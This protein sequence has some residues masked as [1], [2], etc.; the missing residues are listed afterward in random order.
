MARQTLEQKK[1]R[2][3]K[4]IDELE[5]KRKEELKSLKEEQKKL[6]LKLQKQIGKL[7]FDNWG[8]HDLGDIEKA[9]TELKDEALK[10]INN[11]SDLN[12]QETKESN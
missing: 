9:I 5:R 10:I 3:Q 2:L 8:S 6:D 4:R 11:S 12:V 7:V 1:E